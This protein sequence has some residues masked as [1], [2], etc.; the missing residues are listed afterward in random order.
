MSSRVPQVAAAGKARLIGQYAHPR[1]RRTLDSSRRLIPLY[2]TWALIAGLLLLYSQTNAFTWDEGFHVLTAQLIKHGKKPYLDFVFSQT[3]LNAYWNAGWMFLFGESWRGLHAI[4]SL[5]SAAA[6]VL[7]AGYIRSRF[8]VPEWRLP[9]T[10]AAS[11]FVGLNVLVVRYGG[12][13]QAYGLCLLAITA[14]YRLTVASAERER[15]GSVI[16]AGFCCGAAAASSLLTAPTG[17]VLL[18]WLLRHRQPGKRLPTLL[19]F[20]LGGLIPFLPLLWLAA[21]GPRR[22]F[23]GVVEY[24]FLYRL[25][26]WPGATSQNVDVLGSWVDSGQGL[27]LVLLAA[28]GL[29]W[30]HFR[31]D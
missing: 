14:A 24:N 13:A 6:V 31:S 18:L 22:V 8:P 25:L 15:A 20:L 26:D 28:G 17:A 1:A 27:L 29:L 7:A 16:G 23:F 5:C 11:L 3:P 19:F 21:Q 4:A 9:G 2:F 12:V 10:M 30:I